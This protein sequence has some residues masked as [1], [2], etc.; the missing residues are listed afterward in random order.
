MRKTKY[1]DENEG[2]KQ[3]WEKSKYRNNI[4]IYEIDGI[5]ENSKSDVVH[6][7][8][9]AITIVL[10]NHQNWPINEVFIHW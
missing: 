10:S 2:I 1:G 3:K 9:S 7:Q 8:I 5:F 4:L 6:R